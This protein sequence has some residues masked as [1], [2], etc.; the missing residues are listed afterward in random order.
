MTALAA[1]LE[2]PGL[3]I[4][5]LYLAS[6]LTGL[7]K[8][9]RRAI[10]LEVSGLKAAIQKFTVDDRSHGDAWPLSIYA[11]LE[12]TA[13]WS[14][15]GLSAASIYDRNLSEV[16]N[17][18]ALVAIGDDG[19]S[20]GVGQEIAWATTAGL[21][22]LCLTPGTAMSRQITGTPGRMTVVGFNGDDATRDLHLASWLRANRTLIEDGPRRRHNRRLRY[23]GLTTRLHAAWKAAG[24]PTGVAA[25]CNLSPTAVESVLLDAA[26]LA[27]MPT[28]WLDALSS[29]LRVTRPT[30]GPQLGIRALRAWF[31][32]VER[33]G[34]D[35]NTAERLRLVALSRLSRDAMLDLETP[36]GWRQIM[37][38]MPG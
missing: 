23:A 38:N 27:L 17:S 28:E 31:A 5:R 12:H 6:P 24:D 10:C 3:E 9:D 26:R 22:I 7:N 34:L 33:E 29:E 15:D 14:N 21:P 4:P 16:L 2:G 25:R 8:K 1:A 36:G 11:P 35:D 37:D 13:P 18:D 30:S 32:C 20:A 19:L